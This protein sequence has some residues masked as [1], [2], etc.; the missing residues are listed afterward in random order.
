MRPSLEKSEEG[1]RA[2]VTDVSC[3]NIPHGKGV[4][5]TTVNIFRY[6]LLELFNVNMYV[7]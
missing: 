6:I 3:P 1:E 5:E 7:L 4:E 2:R